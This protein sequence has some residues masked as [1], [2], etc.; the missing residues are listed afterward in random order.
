MKKLLIL[1]FLMGCSFPPPISTGRS[2]KNLEE[3][4][5]ISTLPT[6]G[7]CLVRIY[8]NLPND[9]HI[10]FEY[11]EIKVGPE[12]LGSKRYISHTILCDSGPIQPAQ[13]IMYSF[14]IIVHLP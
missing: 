13:I 8:N 10:I 4:V 1:V 11:N 5:D 7:K 6:N 12:L 9:Q 2:P 3:I 14:L